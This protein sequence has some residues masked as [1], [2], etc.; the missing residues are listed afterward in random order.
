M[1][2]GSGYHSQVFETCAAA[3]AAKQIPAATFKVHGAAIRLIPVWL[4]LDAAYVSK[5]VY[6]NPMTGAIEGFAE[7]R[8]LADDLVAL[9]KDALISDQLAGQFWVVCTSI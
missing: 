2:T 1:P 4:A 7:L 3:A 6:Y 9:D 8:S 5:G